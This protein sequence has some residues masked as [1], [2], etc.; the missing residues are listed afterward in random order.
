MSDQS[1]VTLYL[2]FDTSAPPQLVMAG[3]VEVAN[4]H[5]PYP[6]VSI[7]CDTITPEC[8]SSE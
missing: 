5:L 8:D 1:Q 6:L 4:R 7:S 2:V 3:M